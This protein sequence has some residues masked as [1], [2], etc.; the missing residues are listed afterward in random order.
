MH[1][2]LPLSVDQPLFPQLQKLFQL[3][4]APLLLPEKC[5]SYPVLH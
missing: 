3:S 5:V 4:N 2:G 1:I